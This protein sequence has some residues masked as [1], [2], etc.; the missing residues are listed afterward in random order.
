MTGEQRVFVV[1]DDAGVR[2]SLRLLLISAGF[3]VT[4]YPAAAAFLGDPEP[5]LGCLVAD[6]RMPDMTGLDLQDELIRRGDTLPVIIVTGHGDV[7]LAVRAL[8]GGAV[9]FLEKPFDGEQ[10]LASIKRALEIG[11]RDRTRR[12]SRQEAQHLLDLLTPRER[13]ILDKLVTGRSNKVAAYEL[14]ISP[15]TVEIHR[16]RIMDKLKATNLSDLV[17]IALAADEGE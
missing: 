12:A 14:G 8:K 10:L 13:A 3:K 11:S 15:R 4:C 5:K 2:D 17:R 7:P 9:D 16:A 1:D 6:I